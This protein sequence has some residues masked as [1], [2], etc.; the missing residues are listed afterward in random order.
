MTAELRTYNEFIAA[1]DLWIPDEHRIIRKTMI[2]FDGGADNQEEEDHPQSWIDLND[3]ALTRIFNG[4][5][6]AV[7]DLQLGGRFYRAWWLAVRGESRRFITINGRETVKLDYSGFHARMIYHLNDLAFGENQ[8]PY[9]IPAAR[10]AAGAFDGDKLRRAIKVLTNALINA[11]DR[12]MERA[13]AKKPE[14]LKKGWDF[15]LP[16]HLSPA[17]LVDLIK[18]HHAPIAD[19]FASGIGL[20]LQHLDSMICANILREAVQAQKVVLPVHDSFIVSRED[21]GWIWDKMV[22]YYR[23]ACNGKTPV[24]K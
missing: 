7:T 2:P 9:T 1:Q 14:R 4:V 13:L 6:D 10:E 24:I 18:E 11:T 12:Q 22:H 8:D 3:K 17:A 23:L 15:E 19:R 21:E 5:D 16:D 20:K